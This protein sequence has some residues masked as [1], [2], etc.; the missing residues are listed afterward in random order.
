MLKRLGLPYHS[1]DE[2][3]ED[4]LR[5]S[6]WAKR[7]A[8]EEKEK[9]MAMEEKV[10]MGSKENSVVRMKVPLLDERGSVAQI[11]FHPVSN[12]ITSQ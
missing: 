1:D 3:E 2:E 12:S 9:R 4:E 10:E 11:S 8:T 5:L 7:M 6:K